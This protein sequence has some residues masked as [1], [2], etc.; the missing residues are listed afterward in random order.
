[1][2]EF[3]CPFI[4]CFFALHDRQ[5]NSITDQPDREVAVLN[6]VYGNENWLVAGCLNNITGPCVAEG[7]FIEA[8][9]LSSPES[10]I[11]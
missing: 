1:M 3:L 5:T 11:A 4:F 8:V 6:A 9:A 10:R 2:A 7:K